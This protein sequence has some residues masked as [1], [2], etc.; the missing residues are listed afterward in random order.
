VG[1]T[2]SVPLLNCPWANTFSTLFFCVCVQTLVRSSPLWTLKGVAPTSGLMSFQGQRSW[3][4]MWMSHLN[5][6][7]G[8][9]YTLGCSMVLVLMASLAAVKADSLPG[10]ASAPFVAKVSKF[11][12]SWVSLFP[13]TPGLWCN[14]IKREQN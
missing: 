14:R 1:L 13:G 8:S 5:I 3:T 7:C 9:Q 11:G 12:Y 2:S 10:W 6:L 4:S